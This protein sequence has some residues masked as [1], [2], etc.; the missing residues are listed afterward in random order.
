MPKK[1]SLKTSI[2]SIKCVREYSKKHL[3]FIHRR[4]NE[5]Y[6]DHCLEVADVVNECTGEESIYRVALLHDLLINPE[7]EMLL[8]HSPLSEQEQK[9]ARKMFEL[10]RLEI[11]EKTQDLDCVIDS[12]AQ[13]PKLFSLRMAHRVNDIRHLHRFN[14]TLRRKIAKE[15]I[16]MYAALAGRLGM[17]AWK[18]EIEDTCLEWVYPKIARDLSEK[19]QEYDEIDALCLRHVS[20]LLKRE[21]K[22]QGIQCSFEERRKARY[23]TYRKMVAKKRKFEDL[24]DRLALR[25]ITGDIFDCYKALAVVH[26]VMH[27]IPGKL[28]DYI[29]A[30]KENGYRSI[31]TVV[32][33]LAG[34]SEQP[35]EI[36]IRTA[37]M[38]QSCE[39]GS[40]AHG[41]YKKALYALNEQPARVELFR[42]LA[43]LKEEA[44]SPKEFERAL[45]HY[46]RDDIIGVF[47]S[48]NRLYHFK[49]PI[50]ALDFVCY[51]HPKKYQKLKEVRINGRMRPF[52]TEL[53]DGDIVEARFSRNYQVTRAWVEACAHRTTK[54]HLREN[55][56][57]L[58][59]AV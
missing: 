37:Q 33:P 16:H 14:K 36:Q 23:S 52:N 29:G 21:M 27:P 25:I 58:T 32:Y 39:Y 41:D 8:K 44:R 15:S 59:C 17:E 11:D 18:Y 35:M 53:K 55:L 26:A 51:I 50:T 5:S 7:G 40:A 13:D 48:S 31:H 20:A 1:H 22:K 2:S 42:N 28:K 9:L 57:E 54:D 38:H 19:F 43:N 24:T 3:S 30:P 45:R 12:F 47:N 4:S 34:V 56:K 10:R 46:F 6:A 49:A